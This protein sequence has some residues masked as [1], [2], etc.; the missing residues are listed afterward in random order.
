MSAECL[1][2]RIGPPT[3][4]TFCASPSVFY[5]C[6]ALAL[7]SEVY[8]ELCMIETM[9]CRLSLLLAL[10]SLSRAVPHFEYRAIGLRGECRPRVV[11][12]LEV[13][14][15]LTPHSKRYLAVVG[16]LS[17]FL[18]NSS[19]SHEDTGNLKAKSLT[20]YR[21][22]QCHDFNSLGY[23]DGNHADDHC[24][25][26]FQSFLL[27]R[28]TILALYRDLQ[29]DW[30]IHDIYNDRLRRRHQFG[31]QRRLPDLFDKHDHL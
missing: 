14:Q 26:C 10:I 5:P 30:Q 6:L 22:E 23:G 4:T 9:L 18:A 2:A 12:R 13:G 20:D 16:A 25:K 24:N 21:R 27:L 15:S 11:T 8:P 17:R 19:W 3:S 29:S 1:G 28:C 7:V 31:R